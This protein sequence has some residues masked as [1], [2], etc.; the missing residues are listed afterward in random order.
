MSAPCDRSGQELP[1]LAL[2]SKSRS[3]EDRSGSILSARSPGKLAAQAQACT[4]RSLA[5]L[6]GLISREQGSPMQTSAAVPANM[7]R[8]GRGG[9]GGLAH[10]CCLVLACL[11]CAVQA[12]S[13]PVRHAALRV[14]HD[15]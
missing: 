6:P 8:L 5:A 12:A 13:L 3:C 1:A 4:A 15:G 9:G 14:N 2:V 7:R 11:A 10:R